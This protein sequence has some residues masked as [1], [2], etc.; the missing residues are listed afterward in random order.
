MLIHREVCMNYNTFILAIFYYLLYI[1]MRRWVFGWCVTMTSVSARAEVM[2]L[3]AELRGG[4]T[5]R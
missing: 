1:R 4:L 3:H 5:T 2:R